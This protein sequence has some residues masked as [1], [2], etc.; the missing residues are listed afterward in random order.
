MEKRNAYII[1]ED[2]NPSYQNILKKV[3]DI[4]D[5]K[6]NNTINKASISKLNKFEIMEKFVKYNHTPLLSERGEKTQSKIEAIKKIYSS[7]RCK[8]DNRN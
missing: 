1:K 4:S 3:I 5:K 2:F 8:I 7:S 6:A